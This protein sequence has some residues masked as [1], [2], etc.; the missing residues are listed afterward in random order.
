MTLALKRGVAT[1]VRSRDSVSSLS[2]GRFA[3]KAIQPG[4]L[5]DEPALQSGRKR[6]LWPGDTKKRSVG[7]NRR[8]YEMCDFRAHG[9]G[10]GAARWGRRR[11]GPLS[12]LDST[13]GLVRQA[14]L[15]L[16]PLSG[17]RSLGTRS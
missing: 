5:L 4:K 1:G 16:I 10:V 8:L 11:S 3:M 14:D 13:H 2:R 6:G 12:S 17:R 7:V 9:S 15:R